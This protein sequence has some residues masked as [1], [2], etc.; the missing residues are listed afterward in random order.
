ME[1]LAAFPALAVADAAMSAADSHA[2]L[3]ARLEA[4][5]GE[6]WAWALTC[7]AFNREAAEDALQEACLKVLEG[8][9]RYGGLSSFRTWFFGVIRRTAQEHSRSLFGKRRADVDLALV[10][11]QGTAVAELQASEDQRRV[12]DAMQRLPKRQQ[13]TL[14]LVFGHGLTVEEAA[15]V[16]GVSRGSAARHFARGKERLRQWLTR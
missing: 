15:D 9:A 1:N 2:R 11:V 3:L 14:S 12:Q 7:A 13:E 6:A 5:H 8:R 10:P 4:C 16:M